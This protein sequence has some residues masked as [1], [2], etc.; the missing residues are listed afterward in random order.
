MAEEGRE[1]N[2]VHCKMCIRNNITHGKYVTEAQPYTW[3]LTGHTKTTQKYNIDLH[4]LT[5][6]VQ[7]AGT[8]MIS[9]SSVESLT[10][11]LYEPPFAIPGH[12]GEGPSTSSH[13]HCICVSIWY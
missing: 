5:V 8:S 13:Q 3:C 6:L 1:Q 4:R 2:L 11:V 12:S 7:K 10:E 9:T